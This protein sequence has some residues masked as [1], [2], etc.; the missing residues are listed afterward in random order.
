MAERAL[1][2]EDIASKY[3]IIKLD[4]NY[5]THWCILWVARNSY[6]ILADRAIFE[7]NPCEHTAGVARSVLEKKMKIMKNLWKL[8]FEK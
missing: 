6:L 5:D 7:S 8:N 3:K 1:A 4:S 2:S